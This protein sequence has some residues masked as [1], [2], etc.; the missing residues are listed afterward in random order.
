MSSRF[1]LAVV[2]MAAPLLLAATKQVL[3]HDAAL[4][5]SDWRPRYAPPTSRTVEGLR[6]LVL[7][8]GA[9]GPAGRDQVRQCEGPCPH[10]PSPEQMP[11]PGRNPVEDCH[12]QLMPGDSE[13][14][15]A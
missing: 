9:I 2:A 6:A 5:Q 14:H 4:R 13:G 15:R 3:P 11:L 8:H 10:Q 1:A 12:R 7:G